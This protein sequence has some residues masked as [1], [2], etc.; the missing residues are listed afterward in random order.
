MYDQGGRGGPDEL[1]LYTESRLR[2]VLS[3]DL[4]LEFRGA[5]AD[6]VFHPQLSAT[7]TE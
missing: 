5:V 3:R 1:V 7:A 6:P 4:G 2:F